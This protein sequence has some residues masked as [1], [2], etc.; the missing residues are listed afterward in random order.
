MLEKPGKVFTREELLDKIWGYEATVETRVA[1]E[2]VRRIRGKL[3][4]ANSKAV[5]ET[6][7]GFGYRLAGMKS[8]S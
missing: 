2:T 4:K 7:W 1:D 5:I 6:V 8:E 3:A